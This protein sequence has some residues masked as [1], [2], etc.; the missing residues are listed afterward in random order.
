MKHVANAL[1]GLVGLAAIGLVLAAIY[2]VGH[3][4]YAYW[5]PF[6]EA[7]GPP[8]I[9]LG[10]FDVIVTVFGSALVGTVAYEIGSEIIGAIKHHF[11]L[12]KMAN[13][14]SKKING[15]IGKSP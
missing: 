12:K 14:Y 13:Y 15:K 9:L 1:K 11:A 4:H 6:N 2:G 5:P 3:L 7:Y 8:R 10:L